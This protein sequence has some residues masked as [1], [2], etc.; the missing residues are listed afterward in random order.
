MNLKRIYKKKLIKS[1]V[2][3]RFLDYACDSYMNFET[4]CTIYGIIRYMLKEG[5]I[6]EWEY[7]IINSA[8]KLSDEEKAR[9][10]Y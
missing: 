7:N 8:I 9:I 3:V 5:L 2:A 4:K 1:Q 6:P 10:N